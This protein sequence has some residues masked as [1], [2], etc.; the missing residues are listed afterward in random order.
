MSEAG[1]RVRRSSVSARPMSSSRPYCTPE[2]L[3]HEVDAPARAVELIAQQLVGGTGRETETAV[4]AGAQNRL[5]LAPLRGVP[6][7]IGERGP[8]KLPRSRAPCVPAG[9]L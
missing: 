3:L 1:V 5:R 2:Q 9:G 8:H 7:E 4:H 6:D